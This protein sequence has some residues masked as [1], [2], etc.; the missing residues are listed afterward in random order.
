MNRTGEPV[1]KVTKPLPLTSPTCPEVPF[2]ALCVP[3]ALVS[4]NE[5]SLSACPELRMT[6]AANVFV[7]VT[8]MTPAPVVKSARALSGASLL[9]P[10][11][12][13][14]TVVACAATLKASTAALARIGRD[15][16]FDI[17]H[18]PLN[19]VRGGNVLWHALSAREVSV[20][21]TH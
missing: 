11:A 4:V 7:N 5:T 9:L 18:I 6:L 14:L 12:L 10:E 1:V 3:G 21:G 8:S 2:R 17:W 19:T 16:D 20:S 15:F 13:K